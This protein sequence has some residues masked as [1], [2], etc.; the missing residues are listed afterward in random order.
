MA[1]LDEVGSIFTKALPW[2]SAGINLLSTVKA[3][4]GANAIEKQ[5]QYNAQ[6]MREEADA[7][8]TAYRDKAAIL[9]EQQ[10][11]FYATQRTNYLKSGVELQGTPMA[12]LADIVHR[13]R[14]DQVALY[15][16]AQADYIHDVKAARLAEWQGYQEADAVR[17][18]ALSNFGASLISSKLS[19]PVPWQPAD[20]TA[21]VD[22]ATSSSG[23][24]YTPAQANAVPGASGWRPARAP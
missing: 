20:T 13:Q 17:S 9:T 3:Y 24:H 22:A 19:Y 11:L 21:V 5:G 2:V 1:L 8:W 23:P 4:Q 7:G 16:T 18:K 6:Q 12:V 15:H 10:R 14:M